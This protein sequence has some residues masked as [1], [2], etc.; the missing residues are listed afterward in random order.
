[1]SYHYHVFLH[2]FEDATD[3]RH[4]EIDSEKKLS[5]KQLSKKAIKRVNEDAGFEEEDLKFIEKD[6]NV[7]LIFEGNPSFVLKP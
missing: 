5:E 2:P 6:W 1:M 7:F 4:I 3:I